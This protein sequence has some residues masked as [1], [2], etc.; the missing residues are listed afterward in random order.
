M[1]AELQ[2]DM[3]PSE[4]IVVEKILPRPPHVI[5]SAIPAFG[6][7]GLP[8][9]RLELEAPQLVLEGVGIIALPAQVPP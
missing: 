3:H 6:H 1:C 7:K 9:G 4:R 8:F 5:E 2:K